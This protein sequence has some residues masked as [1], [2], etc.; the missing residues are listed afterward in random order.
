MKP[1]VYNK[2]D[3]DALHVYGLSA[4]RLCVVRFLLRKKCYDL[5]QL[6]FFVAYILMIA[7]QHILHDIWIDKRYEL[8]LLPE[9][10][11]D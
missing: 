3:E 8:M 1:G 11:N 2:V 6:V 10:D 4:C 5:T 9:M 7:G